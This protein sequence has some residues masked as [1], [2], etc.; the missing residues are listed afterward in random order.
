MVWWGSAPVWGAG[1][2]LPKGQGSV[3]SVCKFLADEECNELDAGGEPPP[4]NAP[5]C[6]KP[7]PAPPVTGSG[8][9][10]TLLRCTCTGAG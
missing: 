1:G 10:P 4:T 9:Q 8:E 5:L 7:S 3:C 2:A 6:A